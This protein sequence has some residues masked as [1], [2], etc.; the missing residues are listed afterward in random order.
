MEIKIIRHTTPN[1]EKG[2]CYGQSNIGVKN[3]FDE[4]AEVV[5]EKIG[6][7]SDF[8]IYSSPLNRC[9]LLAQKINPNFTVSR[10]ILEMFFGDWELVAW[11]E[12]PR[13]ISDPW[14]QDFVNTKVPNGESYLDLHKRV[15]SFFDE[16]VAKN[17]NAVIVTHSGVIRSILSHITDLDL[18]DSFSF[19]IPYGCVISV[20]YENGELTTNFK[21]QEYA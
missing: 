8:K 14:M 10:K 6:S 7:V 19:E 5:L 3:T 18:K 11:D 16:I 2:M 21:L 1:I 9:A 20:F 12:I 17:E 13:E 15:T 4:E